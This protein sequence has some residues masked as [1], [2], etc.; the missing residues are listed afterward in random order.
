MSDI[1]HNQPPK[2]E[3]TSAF[4]LIDWID[5]RGGLRPAQTL[6]AHMLLVVQ[7]AIRQGSISKSFKDWDVAEIIRFVCRD[8]EQGA[9]IRRGELALHGYPAPTK[10]KRSP[11]RSL[12]G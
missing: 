7:N 8:D 5:E 3:L 11:R 12:V 4:E 10:R 1:G 2:S 9:S 6:N